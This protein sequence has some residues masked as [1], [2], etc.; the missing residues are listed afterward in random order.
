MTSTI[1]RGDLV[2]VTFP[3]SGDSPDGEFED[4]HP[5][6]V[7][8]RTGVNEDLDSTIVVPVTSSYDRVDRV[9]EVELEPGVDGVEIHSVAL[10]TKLTTVS[11]PERIRDEPDWKMGEVS[12]K[13]LND[14]EQRLGILLG[15][16]R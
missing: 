13:R 7:M 4:P 10:L 16:G 9:R 15:I 3:D 2:R 1:A 8:Q 6:V 11:I 14:M 12:S 5:A